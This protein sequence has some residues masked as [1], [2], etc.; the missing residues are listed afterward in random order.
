M[1]SKWIYAAALIFGLLTCYFLYDFLAEVEKTTLD[2]QT[3]TVVVVTRNIPA[4]TLLTPEM[5]DVK[6]VPLGS[7]HAQAVREIKDGVGTITLIPLL[8][9]EQLLR[10]KLAVKDD[11]KNGLAYVIPPGKRAM[12][13]PIDAIS[14]VADMLQPGDRV[15]VLT[16]VSAITRDKEEEIYSVVVLQNIEILAVG[17]N[18]DPKNKVSSSEQEQQGTKTVTL[19]VTV[20][21]A[22]SLFLANQ[23]GVI[24]LMLR[25]PVDDETVTASPFPQDKLL[26]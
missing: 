24:R 3:E 11:F 16:V 6:K 18:I 15:D 4:K 7:A 26:E 23:Q 19:A 5:L 1:K 22:Q 17:K 13:I 2:A 12:S 14:G 25:S 21:E 20:E 10:N 8:E 9:G